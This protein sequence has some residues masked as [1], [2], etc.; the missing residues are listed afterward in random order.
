MKDNDS[1][2]CKAMWKLD[3][4]SK[5]ISIISKCPIEEPCL[6]LGLY[7]PSLVID[8]SVVGNLF[9]LCNCYC[10][11]L[12]ALGFFEMLPLSHVDAI[13]SHF[14]RLDRSEVQR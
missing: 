12:T 9:N 11:P 4:L 6:H 14:G 5:N 3:N 1:M 2:K 8:Y 7:P 13:L 10:C